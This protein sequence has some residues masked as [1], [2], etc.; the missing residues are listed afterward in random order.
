MMYVCSM[1]NDGMGCESVWTCWITLPFSSSSSSF[2]HVYLLLLFFSS[3]HKFDLT[4]APV[5]ISQFN[6]N[7]FSQIDAFMRKK[8]PTVSSGFPFLLRVLVYVMKFSVFPILYKIFNLMMTLYKKMFLCCSFFLIIQ[9]SQLFIIFHVFLPQSKKHLFH[10]AVWT[11]PFV[12]PLTGLNEWK[13]KFG[14]WVPV[15]LARVIRDR[16]Y[17]PHLTVLLRHACLPN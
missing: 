7:S 9:F 14:H 13:G 8:R 6:E 2:K 4:P 5:R 11:C 16:C 3:L 10:S 15:L 12:Y 1:V 17:V